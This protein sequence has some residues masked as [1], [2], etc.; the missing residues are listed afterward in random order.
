MLHLALFSIFGA[1]CVAGAV[2][3][4]IQRHPINSALSLIAVLASLAVEYLL[5]G[6]E[7]LAAVQVIVYAGA[8]MVLFVFT[9]M[10]LNAGEEERTRGSRVAIVFGIPGMLVGGILVAWALLRYSG[11][12]P[13]SVGVLPGPPNTIAQLLF[14]DFLL[15]FEVTSLLIL[16][17]IMGAVVLARGEETPRPAT[18]EQG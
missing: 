15:P 11:T 7:F 3:V 4:L 8:I 2:N 18:K 6:A 10:L 17:A 9:I 1:I 14:H 12:G 13:V 16:I 5:L